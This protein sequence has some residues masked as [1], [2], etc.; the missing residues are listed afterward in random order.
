MTHHRR[1]DDMARLL[2]CQVILHCSD[3]FFPVVVCPLGWQHGVPM[4]LLLLGCVV[5]VVGSRKLSF[6]RCCSVGCHVA[7]GDVAPAFCVKKGK[8]K[9]GQFGY[10][11]ARQ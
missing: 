4:L 2:T 6:T 1:L 7:V 10:L 3:V 9:E 11:P 5:E 8:G